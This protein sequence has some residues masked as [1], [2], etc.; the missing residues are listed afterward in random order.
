M[1]QLTLPN[2]DLYFKHIEIT[3]F[4]WIDPIWIPLILNSLA[5]QMQTNSVDQRKSIKL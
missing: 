2:G 4:Y 5:S 3:F 1:G